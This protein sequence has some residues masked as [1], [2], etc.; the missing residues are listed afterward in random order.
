METI[1][2]YLDNLFSGLPE[3]EEL[4]KAKENLL[5][6]MEDKYRE[7]KAQ[8]R[9]ENEAIGV[10]ISEFGNIDELL[11]ELGIKKTPE[12]EE[13]DEDKVNARF[14]SITEVKE[15]L[16]SQINFGKKIAL[17]VMLC[18]LS[19]VLLI[20]LGAMSET[21]KY[22]ITEG[23]ASAI[24]FTALFVLVAIAVAIFIINAI[25]ADKY[26]FLEKELITLDDATRSYVKNENDNYNPAFAKKITIGVIICILSVV[27]I[28]IEGCIVEDIPANDWIAACCVGL[29]LIL[30]AIGVYI[31]VIAGIRK[32]N[33]DKL[34]QTNDYSEYKKTNKTLTDKVASIY[35]PLV[36]V[37]YLA[38][39]FITMRWGFTW[40]V[41]PIAGVSF[42]VIAAICGV[43]DNKS[44]Q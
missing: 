12:I 24:G 29:L 21:N 15:Y 9:N 14:V 11:E 20:V 4:L 34:L 7:L 44:T 43:F 10:V 32:G 41:W 1:K 27:P 5:N 19:P 3:S 17:G 6:M 42:G 37:G 28:I 25:A 13:P 31:L 33:F 23:L 39:S 8:G 38:W 40:I 2:M 36:T 16:E 26:S 30:V 18:V 22:G 35:W